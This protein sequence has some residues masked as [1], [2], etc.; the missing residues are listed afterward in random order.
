MDIL[1]SAGFQA[2]LAGGCVRDAIL[3]R[4]PHDLDVATDAKPEEVERLFPKTLGVGKAFGVIRVLMDGCD[5]EVAT[6]RKDGAYKDGRRPETIEFSDAREDAKRRDFTINALFLNPDTNEV[7]DFVSGV[8][9]IQAG[10]LRAVGD[11]S[12][13]F[14]EDQLRMLRAVRFAAQLGFEIEDQTLVAIRQHAFRI[15]NVS[16]ERIRDELEK[17]FLAPFKFTHLSL[18][19]ASGLE[20]ALFPQ[21]R[22]K[23]WIDV[24]VN[25]FAQGLCLYFYE[26]LD[27]PQLE[28]YLQLLKISTRDRKFF[29]AFKKTVLT[30]EKISEI[31]MGALLQAYS[32]PGVLFAFQVFAFEFPDMQDFLSNLHQKWLKMGEALPPALVTGKDLMLEKEWD[33]KKLGSVLQE[34][35]LLQLE[36]QLK[37][38]EEAREYALRRLRDI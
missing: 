3:G 8:E 29:D 4:R 20:Q 7:L 2:F 1:K 10:I 25:H 19:K 26:D 6:F 13:R 21:L 16:G 14:D 22:R 36:D 32:D 12:A 31:R 24:P 30:R 28:T 11:A 9:D 5:V 17:I 33:G 23:A 35:Y 38:S 34:T 37:N 15:V 27:N 18:L